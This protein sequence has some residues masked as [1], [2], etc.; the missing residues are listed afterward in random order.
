MYV[1]WLVGHNDKVRLEWSLQNERQRRKNFKLELVRL[2]KPARVSWIFKVS[3]GTKINK[4]PALLLQASVES[5][6]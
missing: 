1:T 3:N 4:N 2:D 5:H 6:S